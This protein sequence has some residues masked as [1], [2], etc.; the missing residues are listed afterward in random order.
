MPP[1][2]LRK[3]NIVVVLHKVRL[4]AHAVSFDQEWCILNLAGLCI[5]VETIGLFG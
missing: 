2:I 5:Q 1:N 4:Q 3:S